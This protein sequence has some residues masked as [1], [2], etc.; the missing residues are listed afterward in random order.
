MSDDPILQSI[1][2]DKAERLR[3]KIS[4]RLK[5]L[6]NRIERDLREL[7]L[8]GEPE[9]VFGLF[10][11]TAGAAQYIGNGQ[12]ETIKRVIGSVVSKWDESEDK[13]T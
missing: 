2:R 13:Q 8:P 1:A 12:R 3:E 9:P 5:H 6:G 10:V 11:L 7:Q 4:Q